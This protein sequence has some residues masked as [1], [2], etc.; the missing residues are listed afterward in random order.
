MYG[1]AVFAGALA[2]RATDPLVVDIAQDLGSTAAQVALLGTAFTLPFAFVQ[3]ILGPV[4][5]AILQPFSVCVADRLPRGVTRSGVA[6]L[7]SGEAGSLEAGRR[8]DFALC[9]WRI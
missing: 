5:D 3:P 6:V 9:L 7:G 8:A 1:P 4:A 2:V